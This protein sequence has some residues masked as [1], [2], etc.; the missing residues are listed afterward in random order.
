MTIKGT[1][2]S[3]GIAEGFVKIVHGVSDIEA[4]NEGDIL[5]SE[6]TEPSMV[7]MMNKA[8]AIVTDRGGLTSHPAI[9]SRELGIPCV[10]ATNTA[11]KQ[12]KNGMRVK[13]DGSAGEI[14]VIQ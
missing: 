6:I 1:P 14:T 4:F 3:P 9:V 7:I 5:V 10:V 2:A 11:T 13:V 12:L 8:A